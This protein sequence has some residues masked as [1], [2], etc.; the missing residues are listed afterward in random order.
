MITS[1]TIDHTLGTLMNR[2]VQYIIDNPLE[3]SAA[4]TSVSGY[5]FVSENILVWGFSVAIVGEAL[6]MYWGYLKNSYFFM[7]MSIIWLLASINGLI[8]ACMA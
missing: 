5:I 8:N 2:V 6:W 4:I 3:L 7:I 1:G